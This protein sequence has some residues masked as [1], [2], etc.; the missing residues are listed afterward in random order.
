MR[1]IKEFSPTYFLS[2][3]GA[4]GLSVS[5]YMYLMFLVPHKGTPMATFDQ[6]YP[7][8]LKGTWLSFLSG[9]ALVFIIFFAFLHI[10]LLYWNT[11]QYA[12]YKKSEAFKTLLGSNARVTLMA[13]PLT[14]TMTINVFFVLGA[15]F[16]PKLWRVIEYMFPFALTGFIIA[17]FFALKILL[18]YY[19]QIMTEG[20][21]D[22]E[23]N[24]NLSQL[25][26]VFA[27][28]M[29]AVGFAAPAAMS[30]NIVVNAMG[31]FGAILFASFSLILIFIQLTLGFKSIFKQGVSVEASPS[32]WV[33][34]PILTLLGIMSIR[35]FFGL[36]HNLEAHMDKSTLFILTSFVLSLEIVFGLLGYMV[37][38][39]SD[40][41]KKFI[42]SSIKSST[43]FALICPGVAFFV[44]GMFFLNFGLVV[45]GI[46]AKYS[47]AHF[48]LMLPFIYVQFLTIKLFFTLKSKFS[49]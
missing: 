29:V 23:K 1:F 36:E 19:S 28:A 33:M 12:N 49:L 7:T 10:K 38:K 6:I 45:N 37:L 40:Y 22:F 14:Y 47:I 44:F 21:F 43:A 2:S 42:Y 9:F 18:E 5:F 11:K 46:V 4:G 34:I 15:T 32:L 27:L 48:I 8:L 35:L 20:N 25:L 31:F 17:G 3:L 39:Q 41:F 26:A 24:N 13:I 30:H 16:V